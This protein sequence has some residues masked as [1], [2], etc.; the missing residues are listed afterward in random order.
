MKCVHDTTFPEGGVRLVQ[1]QLDVHGQFVLNIPHAH[2]IG[3]SRPTTG[4]TGARA[5]RRTCRACS[6][7]PAF[8]TSLALHSASVK[9]CEAGLAASY[10]LHCRVHVRVEHE[11]VGV[12]V[13]VS[14]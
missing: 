6:P 11:H 12:R 1:Q 5:A 10:L 13:T 9:V 7:R 3:H 2:L 14:P 8:C 4:S